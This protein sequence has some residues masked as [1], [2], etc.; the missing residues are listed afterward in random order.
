MWRCHGEFSLTLLSFK[1]HIL[2][3]T[4]FTPSI[5]TT[6]RAHFTR[7]VHRLPGERGER[8]GLRISTKQSSWER[9]ETKI[10]ALH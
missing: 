3:Q 2:L 7:S 5:Q 8:L 9:W 10:R 1:T 4:S 6:S